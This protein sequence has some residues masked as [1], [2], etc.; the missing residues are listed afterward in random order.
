[1][2]VGRRRELASFDQAVAGES[3]R[4]VL[5]VHGPGGIGK[6]TLL[7]ELRTRAR[8]ADRTVVLLNGREIDPSPEGFQ[9]AVSVALGERTA[10]GSEAQL[11]PGAVLLVDGYEQLSPINGWLRH[12]LLP[13][14]SAD[15]V[16]V[17]AGRDAPDASWRTDAGWREVVAIHR[18]DHFDEADSGELL[19]RAGVE[20]AVRPHLVRLGRGHPLAMALLA[21]AAVTGTVP[22]TLAEVPD[23][24]SELLESL[25]RGAPTDSHVIG[26]ATCAKAWLTTE[27]LLRDTVGAEAPAVW[28]W[29][30]RRPFIACGP[31]GLWPHDLA[32]DVLD[33]EFERRSPE[34]YRSLHRVVHDHVVG[35]LRAAT[36]LDRQLLAQHL[37]Y[38]HRMSP[39]TSAFYA[40]RAQG[41][42]AVVPGRRDEHDQVLSMTERSMGPASARTAGEWLAEVPENLSVVRGS[43][44][45]AGFAYHVFHPSGSTMEAKDPVTR[46]VL[47]HVAREGPVRPGEQVDIARFLA[48]R[49]DGQR[50]MYAVLAGAASSLIA[51]VSL[52]LAWSFVVVVDLDYWGP[53]FEYLAFTRQ[54]EVEAGGVRHVLYGNDWRR[55]PVDTWLDL[56]NEREHSGGTGPPP[57]SLLRPPPLDRVRFAAAVRSALRD[58]NRPDRL[59]ASPLMGASLAAA[60]GGP[61]AERLRVNLEDAVACLGDDPKGEQLRAVLQRTFVRAAPTQEAAAAVLG[62]PFSTY[63]RYLAKALEQVTDLLWAVEIGEVRLPGEIGQRLGTD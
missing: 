50:D 33:A 37:L 24:V 13:S 22:D 14:L 59:A 53:F 45:V 54:L 12:D 1:M 35:S 40:L 3:P 42:A 10:P 30:E 7:L 20:A 41:S 51:W 48:G 9:T 63:R 46:A 19:A 5:F 16:V 52:P 11:P 28:A 21:D 57:A 31:R 44:G 29:L 60:P 39:L 47:E 23:L 55:F 38:L 2:F 18:L 25:L 36:G 58:L 61:S 56:M 49:Q 6:T 8:A 34:R 26:L 27:D 62:M 32:R 15:N 4:R 17:L 43:D